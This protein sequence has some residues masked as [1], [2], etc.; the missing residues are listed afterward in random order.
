MNK[1]SKINKHSINNRNKIKKATP[2]KGEYV[3]NMLR[4]ERQWTTPETRRETATKLVDYIVANEKCYTLYEFFDRASGIPYDTFNTWLHHEIDDELREYLNAC[5]AY[6]KRILGV[7]LYNRGIE[8]DLGIN[9]QSA[10]LLPQYLGVWL[11]EDKRRAAQKI[12]QAGAG[13][14]LMKELYGKDTKEVPDTGIPYCPK[15]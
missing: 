12:E 2:I 9:T 3:L 1:M 13:A 5:H 7:R 11:D 15:K 14:E 4:K 10:F 8:K 6:A